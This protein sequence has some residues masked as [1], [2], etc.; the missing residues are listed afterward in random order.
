VIR[1]FTTACYAFEAGAADIVLVSEVEDALALQARFAGARTMGEV[2]GLAVNGFDYSNSPAALVGQDL[3]GCRMIQRTSSGTQGVVLSTQAETILA[4][5][6]ACAQATA[7]HIRALAPMSVTF[8]ITGHRP[9]G[10]GDEDQACADY[11]TSLLQ[12][13]NPDPQPYLDRVLHS[14]NAGYFRDPAYSGLP[15]EDLE[16]VIQIDKVNYALQVE[17]EDSLHIMRT[18]RS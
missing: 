12:G 17:R 18:V 15:A 6:F 10:R 7:A 16:H 9:D 2:S 4:A 14:K 1:A 5:S 11:L 8:V 3:R 13:E